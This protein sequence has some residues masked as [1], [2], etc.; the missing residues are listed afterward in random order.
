MSSSFLRGM[1]SS[2]LGLPTQ[3][4]K[5]DFI[6]DFK[7][8]TTGQI[9]CIMDK[10]K[11]LLKTSRKILPDNGLKLEQSISKAEAELKRREEADELIINKFD[12][13]NLIETEFPICGKRNF[14]ANETKNETIKIIPIISTE[15]AEIALKNCNIKICP[16][17]SEIK[18]KNQY[19]DQEISNDYDS[20]DS[21]SHE[22]PDSDDD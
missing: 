21:N 1:N 10:Q 11:E 8:M 6:T 2:A 15:E 4:F 18:D 19:R 9:K 17:I 13:L 3:K 22:E 16:E 20:D 12:G 5:R 14:K 7:K